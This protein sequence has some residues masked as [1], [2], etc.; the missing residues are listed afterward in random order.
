M[1]SS[2]NDSQGYRVRMV[3][4]LGVCQRF[5]RVPSKDGGRAR[6][7]STIHKGSRV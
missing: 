5:T 6:R 1:D 3:A 2:V 7:L 4:G